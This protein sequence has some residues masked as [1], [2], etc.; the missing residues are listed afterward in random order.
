[1]IDASTAGQYVYTPGTANRS[2][3]AAP[4]TPGSPALGVASPAKTPNYQLPLVGIL[5]LAAVGLA[6]EWRR[7]KKGF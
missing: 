1:M 6:L 7:I 5:G 4:P 3:L 2:Q